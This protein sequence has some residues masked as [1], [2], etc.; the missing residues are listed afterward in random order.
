[1][2]LGEKLKAENFQGKNVGFVNYLRI[3]C[4]WMEDSG[5]TFHHFQMGGNNELIR[6]WFGR[7]DVLDEFGC[8]ATTT[9]GSIYAIWHSTVV[10]LGKDRT[11]ARDCGELVDFL[12]QLVD[13]VEKAEDSKVYHPGNEKEVFTGWVRN[14]YPGAK[15]DKNAGKDNK[16]RYYLMEKIDMTG[17]SDEKKRQFLCLKKNQEIP[18][19][20]SFLVN[21]LETLEYA[22]YDKMAAYM[23]NP[24]NNA[25]LITQEMARAEIYTPAFLYHY[26]SAKA[27]DMLIKQLRDPEVMDKTWETEEGDECDSAYGILRCLA[28]CGDETVAKTF[29]KWEKRN[30]Y[31]WGE[32]YSDLKE[33]A[34]DAGWTFDKDGGKQ[35]L[36]YDTCYALDG[37]DSTD[38]LTGPELREDKCPDCGYP[39]VDI[40][41]LDG[42]NPKLSFLGINGKIRIPHC[43]NCFYYSSHINIRYTP[44]GDS[45]IEAVGYN[46]RTAELDDNDLTELLDNGLGISEAPVSPFYAVGINDGT[47][48]GYPHWVQ[49]NDLRGCPDCGT[50]MTFLAQIPYGWMIDGVEGTMYMQI[51]KDCKVITMT[52]DQT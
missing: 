46:G 45:T 6:K 15:L 37:G 28:W 39:L 33:F 2:T 20:P 30:P 32:K 25:A 5:F 18:A 21:V 44:D 48:G 26:A 13:E 19:E 42:N 24:K 16:F 4:E 43:P 29:A 1:M 11:F 31:E 34:L 50:H 14:E 51:C 38:A 49:N 3:L 41:V 52:Y 47:L 36:V 17:W 12:Y 8:F 7:D 35:Q 23:T 40:F 22:D 27:R 9:D 10:C